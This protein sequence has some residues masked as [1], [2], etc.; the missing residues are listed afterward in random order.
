MKKSK[1]LWIWISVLLFLRVDFSPAADPAVAKLDAG[2]T[3]ALSR[4]AEPSSALD[5]KYLQNIEAWLKAAQSRGDLEGALAA[6]KEMETFKLPG[7]RVFTAWPDLKRFREIYETTAARLENDA[8]V[9]RVKLYETYRRELNAHVERLTREGQLED[10][11]QLSSRV[12]EM[13]KLIAEGKT[14]TGA[15][16]VG[17]TSGMGNEVLWE[18]K[19]RANVESVKNCEMKTLP[20]GLQIFSESKDG[21]RYESRKTFKP[22]FRIQARIATDSTNIRFYYNRTVLAIFNWET[23]LDELRIH[24]PGT[25]RNMGFGGKGQLAI[26][27]MHDIELDVYEDKIEVRANGQRLVE[28]PAKSTGL[29]ASVGLG[30]AFGS[31][32]T[33]ESFQVLSLNR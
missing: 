18:F 29:D 14:E 31:V 15:S 23:N 1:H 25:G 21:A 6:K 12:K 22:P 3:A 17:G 7:E 16:P 27:K 33:V 20:N 2:F 32:L 24:E 19:S 9:E 5:A 11:V 10:A 30:P 28:T 8:S 13:D 26:N 4:I